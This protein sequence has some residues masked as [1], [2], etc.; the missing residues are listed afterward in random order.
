M[1]K[2]SSG[3]KGIVTNPNIGFIGRPTVRVCYDRNGRAEPKPYDMN[4]TDSEYQNKTITEIL[5]Y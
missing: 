4:M 1:V 3:E 2:L 5:D